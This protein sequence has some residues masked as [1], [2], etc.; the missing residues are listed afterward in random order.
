[1]L[2][3]RSEHMGFELAEDQRETLFTRMTCMFSSK[4]CNNSGCLTV[5]RLTEKG[6]LWPEA[7]SVEGREI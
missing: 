4:T 3:V 6:I 7:K 2:S 1:M 5:S